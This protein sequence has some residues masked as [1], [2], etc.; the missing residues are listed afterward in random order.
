MNIC[1]ID[2]AEL[3]RRRHRV[4]A[5]PNRSLAILKDRRD[6]LVI[7]LRISSEFAI[8][9]AHQALYCANPES[10]VASD[11]ETHDK[12][13]GKLFA[14]QRWLPLLGA[15]TVKPKQPEYSAQ[16]DVAVWRLHD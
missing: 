2:R 1:S 6:N 8:S 11:I 13:A 10:A 4:D 15:D 5:N 16:P 12:I 14:I 7:K 3:S 9:P